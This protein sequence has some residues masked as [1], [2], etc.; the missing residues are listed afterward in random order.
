VQVTKVFRFDAA[1]FLKK[2]GVPEPVFGKCSQLHG[3]TWTLYVTVEGAADPNTGMVIDFRELAKIVKESVVD[4]L[5]HKL[6]NDLI[7]L[8]TCENIIVWISKQ[9]CGAF[10]SGVVLRRLTLYETPDSY[11]SVEF[12]ALF[13]VHVVPGS[14]STWVTFTAPPSAYNTPTDT[15]TKR[16]KEKRNR[17]DRKALGRKGSVRN[18]NSYGPQE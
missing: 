8:P 13:T 6:L 9:L 5:D 4:V 1:H 17:R 18:E 10:P 14:T 12:P 7:E 15:D 2:E 11:A 3:H 16:M